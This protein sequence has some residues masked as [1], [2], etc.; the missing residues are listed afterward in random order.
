[1]TLYLG[2]HLKIRLRTTTSLPELAGLVDELAREIGLDDRARHTLPL[3]DL[4]AACAVLT[5]E[6]SGALACCS[7]AGQALARLSPP[8]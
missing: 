3:P 8:A 7:L 1:M 4:I 2:S 5:K 6:D